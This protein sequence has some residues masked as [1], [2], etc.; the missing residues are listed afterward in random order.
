MPSHT[1][2]RPDKTR[3]A[4]VEAAVEDTFPASDPVS[5]TAAHGARAVPAEDMMPSQVSAQTAGL[6]SFTVPFPKPEDA[7]LALET[8]VREGP[9]DRRCAEITQEGGQ[10]ALRISAPEADIARLKSM[11]S[12]SAP[13]R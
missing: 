3:D 1:Q 8:L 2:D 5:N 9:V 7:K 13:A 12:G 4:N 10:T 6:A 11:L